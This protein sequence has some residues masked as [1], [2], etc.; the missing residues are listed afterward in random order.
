M[1]QYGIIAPVFNTKTG[2]GRV[3][4][5]WSKS[6]KV[7]CC[8]NEK[9]S[10]FRMSMSAK[11]ALR[12]HLS[13]DWNLKGFSSSRKP[14]EE[15]NHNNH[16]FGATKFRFGLSYLFGR[17][18]IPHSHRIWGSNM[19][20]NPSSPF[21]FIALVIFKYL[22]KRR[23]NPRSFEV[24]D[25]IYTIDNLGEGGPLDPPSGLTVWCL[26]KSSYGCAEWIFP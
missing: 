9:N 18:K 26:G 4:G 2:F 19:L 5:N 15:I 25:W 24:P 22:M 11:R 20:S 14:T 13:C 8:R 3:S 12:E 7:N 21:Y 17:R 6:F 1:W 16:G 23:K 10:S